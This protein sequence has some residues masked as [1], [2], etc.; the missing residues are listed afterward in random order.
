[1]D[2]KWMMALV[3][4]CKVNKKNNFSY[5]CRIAGNP[6]PNESDPHH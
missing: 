5:L 4:N 2:Y 1:M 3:S 6:I